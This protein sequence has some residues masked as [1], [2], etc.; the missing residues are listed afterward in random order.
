MLPRKE[1]VKEP[2]LAPT[3]DPNVGIDNEPYSTNLGVFHITR[4]L[5][6]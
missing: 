1:T 5:V 2:I 6:P 4:D 3:M